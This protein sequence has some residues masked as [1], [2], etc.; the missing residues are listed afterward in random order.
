MNYSGKLVIWCGCFGLFLAGVI[1]SRVLYDFDLG[2][3]KDTIEVGSYIATIIA[4]GVAVITL[5]AWRQQW[6]YAASQESLKRLMTS[7]DDLSCARLYLKAFAYFESYKFTQPGTDAAEF[8][9][10]MEDKLYLELMKASKDFTS[11]LQDVQLLFSGELPGFLS[12]ADNLS[13]RIIKITDSIKKACREDGASTEAVVALASLS[14]TTLHNDMYEA[15]KQVE[16]LRKSL[17]GN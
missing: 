2:F 15:K 12:S 8:Y 14:S 1:W 3:I 5:T 9:K 4:A 7:L 17:L 6:K 13:N 10:E 16:L 11:S